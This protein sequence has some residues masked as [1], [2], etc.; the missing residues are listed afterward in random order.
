MIKGSVI[1]PK[2]VELRDLGPIAVWLRVRWR[3]NGGPGRTRTYDQTVMSG[4]L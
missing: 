1:D 2:P 4:R 3:K